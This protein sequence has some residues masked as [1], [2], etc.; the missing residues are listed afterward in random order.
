MRNISC[1]ADLLVEFN[2]LIEKNP[3]AVNMELVIA[4]RREDG[5]EE[6]FYAVQ[7]RIVEIRCP[8]KDCGQKHLCVAI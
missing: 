3:D 8:N 4:R 2:K 7:P 1:Y 5:T 6:V